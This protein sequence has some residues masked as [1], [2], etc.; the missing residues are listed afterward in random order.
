MENEDSI[1]ILRSTTP[2]KNEREPEFSTPTNNHTTDLKI[3]RTKFQTARHTW[4]DEL[5]TEVADNDN[6][7]VKTAY[8]EGPH[9]SGDMNKQTN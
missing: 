5:Q 1:E 9:S 4:E 8:E 7:L 6:W 3:G 2:D